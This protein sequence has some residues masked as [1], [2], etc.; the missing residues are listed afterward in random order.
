MNK[1]INSLE[2]GLTVLRSLQEDAGRS[3]AELHQA[4]G[5]PKASLLRIL[6]TLEKNQFAWR[7]IG[8]GRYRRSISLA[9][10]RR[11]DERNSRIAEIAAPYLEQLQR[12]VIWPSDILVYR[13]GNLQLVETSRRQSNLG[14]NVYR[15]GFR[16]DMFLSAPGRA[17]LAFCSAEERAAILARAHDDPPRI[18]RSRAVLANELSGILDETRRL[19]YASRDPLF[20]GSEVDIGEVDDGLDAIAVPIRHGEQVLACMNLVWPR[21]YKLKAKIVADHLGDML[22]TA[23]AIA[24]ACQAADKSFTQ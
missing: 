8:D 22:D 18:A 3:L 17:Y 10:R 9:T 23:Q 14:L 19:G 1:T 5:I 24:D 2:R 12:K 16:V 15:I 7:A 4:T 13:D 6:E 11:Y 20:G 21:K